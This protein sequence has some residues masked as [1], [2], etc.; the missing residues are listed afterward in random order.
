MIRYFMVS[1]G[2]ERA[3]IA[4]S[5]R[6]CE[7]ADAVAGDEAQMPKY[8]YPVVIGMTAS[9]NRATREA[10]FLFHMVPNFS[11]KAYAPKPAISITGGIMPMDRSACGMP[12]RVSVA[13]NVIKRSHA[14][15]VA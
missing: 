5:D 1:F 4:S 10:N 12:S 15:S 13:G 2:S 9:S 8:R 11:H 3:Y 7:N 14:I 6:S